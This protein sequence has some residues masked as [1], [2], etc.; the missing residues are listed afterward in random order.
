MHGIEL[1]RQGPQR[2]LPMFLWMTTLSAL[3]AI[4]GMNPDSYIPKKSSSHRAPKKSIVKNGGVGKGRGKGVKRVLFGKQSKEVEVTEE[5]LREMCVLAMEVVD[6]EITP[7]M[8]INII[9]NPSLIILASPF[10]HKC[11]GCCG[12]I[13]L[14]IKNTP[15]IWC[16]AEWE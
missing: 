14:K 13:T 15:T 5:K 6:D 10:I 9:K 11:K 3:E 7:E 2:N 1:N 12:T 8:K 4:Q 16:F